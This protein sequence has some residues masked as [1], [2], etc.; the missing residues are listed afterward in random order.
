MDHWG[1]TVLGM[2]VARLK[3]SYYYMNLIS[4]QNVMGTLIDGSITLFLCKI[5]KLICSDFRTFILFSYTNIFLNCV[6]SH[7]LEQP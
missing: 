5:L 3:L 7:I 2:G 6:A 1:I 4:L